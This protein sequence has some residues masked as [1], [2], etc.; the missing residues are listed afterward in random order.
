MDETDG[1]GLKYRKQKFG[2]P[3]ACE[4][5]TIRAGSTESNPVSSGGSAAPVV[6]T[7]S[8]FELSESSLI[9]DL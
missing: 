4:S 7:G 9:F 1:V 2:L 8:P 5:H 3:G 6:L